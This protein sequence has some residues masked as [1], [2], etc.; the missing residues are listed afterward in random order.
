[1]FLELI[2]I[3]N[4]KNTNVNLISSNFEKIMNIL[5]LR[6][7]CKQNNARFELNDSERYQELYTPVIETLQRHIESSS[8]PI[9]QL[10]YFYWTFDLVMNDF[11]RE[12]ISKEVLTKHTDGVIKLLV[13]PNTCWFILWVFKK[14]LDQLEESVVSKFST[15]F[16]S[17]YNYTQEQ[18]IKDW[19]KD[20]FISIYNEHTFLIQ[21][22]SLILR[23]LI[24]IFVKKSGAKFRAEEFETVKQSVI[25]D[26]ENREAFKEPN[27][28][29]VYSDF[30]KEVG[31]PAADVLSAITSGLQQE[32]PI[33]VRVNYIKG[34]GAIINVVTDKL[35]AKE[36]L[37]TTAIF[38]QHLVHGDHLVEEACAETF[39]EYA[40]S[41]PYEGFLL[42]LLR[43]PNTDLTSIY[44]NTFT[45]TL[46]ICC[47]KSPDSALKFK[48]ANVFLNYLK[49][50]KVET[51]KAYDLKSKQLH[52]D[53]IYNLIDAM[54]FEHS[55]TLI[56]EPLSD[57][58]FFENNGNITNFSMVLKI[59]FERHYSFLM[60]H[61]KK[62]LSECLLTA[63][64]YE[65]RIQD[66]VSRDVLKSCCFLDIDFFEVKLLP[67]LCVVRSS[68]LFDP[69][70][71]NF[72]SS[73]YTKLKTHQPLLKNKFF[74]TL[75]LSSHIELL[76]HD[77]S[78]F[79]D[80][81]GADA[82]EKELLPRILLF[83]DIALIYF[84]HRSFK[85]SYNKLPTHLKGKLKT[86][87][88]SKLRG[89][90]FEIDFPILIS[91]YQYYDLQGREILRHL[92]S[93]FEKILIPRNDFEKLDKNV[94]SLLD[95]CFDKLKE[96]V[97]TNFEKYIRFDEQENQ[98][99][100]TFL[101]EIV[102]RNKLK[103]NTVE[104]E[105]LHS[106][107]K[108]TAF[109]YDANRIVQSIRFRIK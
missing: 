33:N 14:T 54:D 107:L 76:D 82:I 83:S 1:M 38:S 21:S 95:Q 50:E 100:L 7:P 94:I 37:Q 74:D 25:Q 60:E 39:A 87:L 70:L 44:F 108:G 92:S 96:V 69:E 52:I 35:T 67:I 19:I 5:I 53:D 75:E 78:K 64:K 66:E 99:I 85:P 10:V 26:I 62:F 6:S 89:A 43:V 12:K 104:Y 90:T 41:I 8:A 103:M 55:K 79:L 15:E 2:S 16:Y 32:L 11:H 102:C 3:A 105:K 73:T 20:V 88:T 93:G 13:S 23:M 57:F 22:K 4:N 34:L 29:K 59:V 40:T 65:Q 30:V 91:L 68:Y 49:F 97:I 77:Y 63:S 9:D 81:L 24:C 72:T 109:E 47:S 80:V 46:K 28:S 98:N 61:N 84:C 45:K 17:I 48:V 86:E 27:S 58:D 51:E 31:L 36:V 101:W 71:I 18:W 42:G 106:R 56:L